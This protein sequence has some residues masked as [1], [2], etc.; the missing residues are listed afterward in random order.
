MPTRL[1]LIYAFLL[2]ILLK[3]TVDA[4]YSNADIASG[5]VIGEL[6]PGSGPVVLGF[7]RWFEAF[8]LERATGWVPGHRYLWTYGAYALT[9][10]SLAAVAWSVAVATGKRWAGF[11]FFAVPFCATAVLMPWQFAWSGHALAWV[12]VLLAGAFLVAS[13]AVG[14][15]FARS[16]P[17]H[18]VVMLI[19][20]A[21]T[22]VGYASDRALEAALIVPILVLAVLA[23]RMLPRPA[24]WRIAGTAAFIGVSSLLLAGPL[25][26]A[27]DKDQI[28]G[29]GFNIAKADAARRADNFN[30][31]LKAGPRLLGGDW[32]NTPADQVRR[33]IMILCAFV[34]VAALLVG[35]GYAAF[36]GVRALWRPRS[37]APA[38]TVFVVFWAL[39][40]GGMIGAF[41]WSTAAQD[42]ESSRY[43]PSTA[44]GVV[45]LAVAAG[46]SRLWSRAVVGAGLGLCAL[47]GVISL[48]HHDLRADPTTPTRGM[49]N[50][51]VDVAHRFGVKKAYA[52]YWDAAPLSW[53][54][55]TEVPV[56]PVD[57]CQP[58]TVCT[59]SQHFAYK[60]FTDSK[61]KTMLVVDRAIGVPRV[62]LQSTDTRFG[63]PIYVEDTG[64][65]VIY[66]YPYDI[67][68]KFGPK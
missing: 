43:L 23:L 16:F 63:K 65:L 48:A 54:T 11:T 3:T 7:V 62:F 46:A 52:G 10:L 38:L 22:A 18:L 29:A 41:I 19:L 1:A 30:L 56:Y 31:F 51:V 64:R 67:F 45:G 15:W 2:I 24:N 35:I 20:S 17:A 34:A 28:L 8:W 21:A 33:L 26:R 32:S 25:Q 37:S 49:A 9:L 4:V 50:Q 42:L 39:S 5:P 13:A 66:V 27:A 14:G 36:I 61:Q 59:F 44:Y 53:Y 47:A 40:V 57:N 55:R 58:N 68:T 60:W 6:Y 12:H